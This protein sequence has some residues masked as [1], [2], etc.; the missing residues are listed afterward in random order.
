MEEHRRLR[1][2]D[3]GAVVAPIIA[4]VIMVLA[5]VFMIG[6]AIVSLIWLAT[7]VPA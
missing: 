5:M 4:A 2:E 3:Q 1:D 7:R 6:G